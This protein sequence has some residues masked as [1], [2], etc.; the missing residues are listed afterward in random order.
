MQSALAARA[1]R[2][3]KHGESSTPPV[4]GAVLGG[5][6]ERTGG[7]SRWPKALAMRS[8]SGAMVPGR[9]GASNKCDY[10]AGMA[11][12]VH[13]E[14]LA[15]D[16]LDEAPEVW[17]VLTTPR[18]LRRQEAFYRS[19]EKLVA[20][21]KRRFPE[22]RYLCILEYTTGEHDERGRRFP[23]WNV[24]LKGV[25]ADDV[26]TIRAV[27]RKVWCKR[28]RASIRAQYVEGV[29][30][31]TALTKYTALHFL[32]ESQRPPDGF[33]GHRVCGSK[34]YYARPAWKL[35][36]DAEASLRMKREIWKAERDG[37]SGTEALVMAEAAIAA[38]PSWECVVRTID[39]ATGEVTG[40]RLLDGG[41]ATVAGR[42][43]RG[44]VEQLTPLSNG[45]GAV[46][47]QRRLTGAPLAP[48]LAPGEIDR[49]LGRTASE[50]PA[51]TRGARSL[52]HPTLLPSCEHRPPP[53]G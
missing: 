18:N 15:L 42:R 45:K 37:F 10:C 28:E 27:V 51:S 21:L 9:C 31:R 7:C 13:S 39:K 48:P 29:R 38:A 40:V 5:L 47:W 23:H 36:A 22:L 16:A 2:L 14:M 44:A 20:A 33:S 1:A 52:C 6:R 12:V 50:P 46:K 35:R 17:M 41:I 24:F 30:D 34:G 4:T 26:P 32:K 19:R 49:L 43:P 8:S 53:H 11:A 25:T 3:D